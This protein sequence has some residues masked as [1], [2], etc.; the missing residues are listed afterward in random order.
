MNRIILPV[1]LLY[2]MS[3]SV[4]KSTHIDSLKNKKVNFYENKYFSFEY[5]LSW[6]IFET[7]YF[8]K[9]IVLRIAHKKDIIS[10]YVVPENILENGHI[11]KATFIPLGANIKTIKEEHLKYFNDYDFLT[12]YAKNQFNISI[13]SKTF[14]NLSDFIN[15]K[16]SKMANLKNVDSYFT[17]I[18]NNHY[19][20]NLRIYYNDKER[21]P[22]L[23]Q[24]YLM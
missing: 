16:R 22:A 7:K 24:D 14:V 17:K 1:F 15:K 10:G 13:E 11:N 12:E 2:F 21:S 9:D 5:P 8:E 18:N 3:C 4:N 19:I 6:K 23:S 20:N